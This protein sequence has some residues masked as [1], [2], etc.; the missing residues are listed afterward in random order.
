MEKIVKSGDNITYAVSDEITERQ[1]DLPTIKTALGETACKSTGENNTSPVNYKERYLQLLNYHFELAAK[2]GSLENE[3]QRLSKKLGEI[4][5]KLLALKEGNE[6]LSVKFE[7]AEKAAS[8]SKLTGLYNRYEWD[9]IIKRSDRL[10]T[11]D[12]D[13]HAKAILFMDINNFKSVNDHSNDH[14]TEGDRILQATADCIRES[15]RTGKD[16][17]A[18]IGGDE[19]AILLDISRGDDD[20]R[21]MS[22]ITDNT[23]QTVKDRINTYFKNNVL[24]TQTDT[25]GNVLNPEFD[26]KFYNQVGLGLAIGY[27]SSSEQFESYGDMKKTADNRMYNDKQAQKQA[28]LAQNKD[29]S[30]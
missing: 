3:N 28:L 6:E 14:H 21:P 8:H 30:R 7:E 1:G 16:M 12:Q 9:R 23:C 20:N 10:E 29:I 17:A 24:T 15:I 19:M 11:I 22:E 5:A 2:Y 18:R 27:A 25:N 4:S 13:S 26:T